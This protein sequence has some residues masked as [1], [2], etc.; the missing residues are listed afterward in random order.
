MDFE[1][2]SLPRNMLTL[3]PIQKE[4]VLGGRPAEPVSFQEPDL[5]NGCRQGNALAYQQLYKVH[6]E[7]MKSIAL[8]MLN[9]VP[10][11][12]DAVQETFVRILR[13]VGA[14]KGE[15]AFTTWVYRILVNACYDMLRGRRRRRPELQ[16]PETDWG[17]IDYPAPAAS[18]HPLRLTLEKS[19]RKLDERQRTVFVLFEVEGFKHREIAEI[20]NIPEG[21]SKN[22][23]FEAKKTLQ[24]FLA[25]ACRPGGTSHV[26]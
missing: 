21:T 22:V 5:V 13:S 1:T 17:S 8:N 24:R 10:D 9:S 18:D 23:L 2:G 20:L 6:G 12:E 7:R 14:F 19:L 16:E 26:D 25:P 4:H 15:A 3:W 11:A